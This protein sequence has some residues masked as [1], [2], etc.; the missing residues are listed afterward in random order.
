M[1]QI[2][3]G[4]RVDSGLAADQQIFWAACDCGTVAEEARRRLDLG[5]LA[6]VAL[7][8][9]MAGAAMLLRLS[10][11]RTS[12]LELVV[13]GD[14]PLRRVRVE[15][16]R[17]GSVRGLVADGHAT[18]PGDGG[19]LR[20]GPGFGEGHLRV[21]R[22]DETGRVYESR[23]LLQTG[24]IGVDLAHYLSQS[25]QRAS[26]VLVG[27]LADQE[28]IA[29]AGGLLV[30]ALPG[31]SAEV[32]GELER[33]SIGLGSVSRALALRGL[34]GIV[35]DVIGSFEPQIL[36]SHPL[37][38]RCRCSREKLA[39]RLAT[40]DSTDIDE[41]TSEGG[42]LIDAECAYCGEIYSFDRE[43]LLGE[44]PSD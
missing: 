12:R 40:L 17:D 35:E 44:S 21:V 42:G 29:A 34:G 3:A 22:E 41:L 37:E 9:I 8:R 33:R 25:E 39:T 30:E 36:S 13:E 5:P 11:K 26:A 38:Y 16:D 19:E 24:E 6:A 18:A 4:P 27:V 23:V 32:I 14:G 1:S 7:G 31:C 10:S 2:V 28:G 20:V 15:V 43:E